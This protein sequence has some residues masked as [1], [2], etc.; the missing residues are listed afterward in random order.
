MI[1]VAGAGKDHLALL[2]K[3]AQVFVDK[4]RVAELE[5]AQSTADVRRILGGVRHRPDA[6]PREAAQV[7]PARAPSRRSLPGFPANCADSASEQP[8]QGGG[9][10]GAEDHHQE[11]RPQQQEHDRDR[12]GRRPGR[13][14]RA[15]GRCRR[16]APPPAPPAARPG[17]GRRSARP[18][19]V[20][21][22]G[23]APTARPASAGSTRAQPA[24]TAVQIIG[25]PPGSRSGPAGRTARPPAAPPRRRPARERPAGAIGTMPSATAAAATA[26]SWLRR[27]RRRGHSSARNA[28][29]TAAS[30]PNVRGSPR[31]VP[32]MA[33]PKRREVPQHEDRQPGGQEAEPGRGPG[34]PGHR[35]GGGL[36]DDE[37]GGEQPAPA[38]PLQQRREPQ[39]VERVAGAEQQGRQGPR[40]GSAAGGEDADQ[41]ELRGA[42]E[43]QQR[44]GAGLR[45]R[46]PRRHRDGAERDAVRTGGQAHAQAVADD[47]RALLR[48]QWRRWTR[49]LRAGWEKSCTSR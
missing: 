48:V 22:P 25:G 4:E 40:E 11:R 16:P 14:A 8:E 18:R 44:Q 21:A 35:H 20:R 39:A 9:E 3:I 17:S 31:T 13:R 45:D 7:T 15:A 42:G 24:M 27:S 32:A 29:P 23:A 37:V 43:H 5:A 36:V 2:G 1:G 26:T 6:A 49:R 12:R 46:E 33:P 47:R 10:R 28:A 38:R 34:G 30:R 41:G 19:A